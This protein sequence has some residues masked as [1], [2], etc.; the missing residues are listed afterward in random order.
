M[1][2]SQ[3]FPKTLKNPPKDA[4]SVSHKYLI[5]GGYADQL[6]AGVYTYLPLGW[7]VI[8]KISDI[9]REEMN[10][11]GGQEM[12]MPALQP[13]NIWEETGRWSGGLSDVMY[14][15]KDAS[16]KELGLAATHEEV[17]YDIIRRFINSYKDLPLAVYQIQN[18]FRNELRAK[19]G[20]MR[21]RE[22]MMK[23]LYS[24]HS[25]QADMDD[26]YQKMIGA[27]K[28]VYSRC[29]LDVKV[30]EA[31]GGMFT[32]NFSHEFQVLSE[33]GEDNIVYC[34]ACDWAQNSEISKLKVG[35]KCPKCGLK[36]KAG[37][38]IEVGNIFQFADKYAKDMNGFVNDENSQ[39][40]PILMA[41]YGIGISRLVATIV[42]VYHDETGIRWPVSVA[43]YQVHLISL[44][45]DQT[46]E[47]I[48]QELIGA[49]IETLYDDRDVS[50]GQ[51]FADADLLGLPQRLVV[52]NKTADKI[53]LKKRNS[54]ATELLSLEEI[55]GL[56]KK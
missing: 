56:L 55:I 5:Q 24:F 50:A 28:K 45:E 4:T 47:K 29:G 26:Y 9:I 39:K 49:G 18:K 34:D 48:Y 36:I 12:L 40:Q 25:S 42:E 14:Q 17:V 11:C 27:Y 2:Q 19:G 6:Q 21:G 8:N 22:F 1:R 43:P 7:R 10:A 15:F 35:D 46:A 30:V 31:S 52:S 54:S 41:S 33:A 53:E 37:K 38:S 44:K 51:K 16:G 23:D 32:Q 13:K 3:L 20:L